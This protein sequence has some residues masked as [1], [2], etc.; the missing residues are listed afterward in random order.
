MPARLLLADLLHPTNHTKTFPYAAGCV[1]AP[2]LAEFGDRV[3]IEVFRTTE[4]LGEAFVRCRPQVVAFSNYLWNRMLTFDVIG[5]I[6]RR[7]PETVIVVGGPN[8]PDSADAQRRF[9]AA[10]PGIDFYVYKE[11]ELP[12][13]DLYRRLDAAGFDA[14]ALRASRAEIPGVHYLAGDDL[15]AAPPPPRERDL[16]TLPSPYLAGLLD[17]F[18]EQPGLTPLIQTKRGCPFQCTF[19]VE[20]ADYYTKLASVGTDR[21]REEIEYI[22]AR[23]KGSPVLHIADSN[24]GMYEHDLE[25]CD[26]LAEVRDRYG[27]PLT[28]EVSTGK[29]RKERVLEAVE[30]TG[31]AMR[32]GPALQTTDTT[33]LENIKRSNISPDQLVESAKDAAAMDQR[34]YTELILGLPGD[35]PATH[36]ESIRTAMEAGI[37]RIRMY[38]LV[39]LPG[40][41]MEAPES[42][43]R[44]ALDARHRV[45]PQCHGTYEFAGERFPSAEIVEYVLG[46]SSMSFDEFVAT[47]KFELSVEIFYGDEYLEEV[48]GLSRALGLSMFDFVERCHARLDEFPAD[49]ARH[50]DALERGVT[51]H[52]W[53][54]GDACREH[55][56]D[57][58]RLAAYAAVE[59]EQSLGTLKAM[60]LVES[61]DSVLEIAHAAAW[62]CI[63]AAGRATPALRDYVD[64]LF[65]YSRLRR[66]RVL[67][68]SL[69]LAGEFRFDFSAIDQRRY[70]VEPDGFRL[71]TP[72]TMKF[73]H[74]ETQAAAIRSLCEA[75]E[76]PAVRARDFVYPKTDPGLNPY[77]RRSTFS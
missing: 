52:L 56:S 30:R 33:T 70:E 64:E 75:H 23:E 17:P 1:A 29:N 3:Q 49:L 47:K 41:E 77:I 8:Y 5:R 12:F 51:A 65:A 62:E 19:C 14:E 60:A 35:T 37:Q 26:L 45:L 11:G 42:R 15:V 40:T 68:P 2:V 6:K 20:G 44:F 76:H 34:T 32:F 31:G 63:V 27:W 67:E 71:E 39:L 38:S 18:F 74:D 53:H 48:H 55:Y 22:A 10:Q 57:P 28:I 16:D 72:G 58:E 36:R 9:L 46:S 7:A 69:E 50:Y 66:H 54:D 25:L 43:E 24:F 73:W 21:F 61:I 13:L 4:S 59:Y